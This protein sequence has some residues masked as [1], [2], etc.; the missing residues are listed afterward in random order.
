MKTIK[1]LIILL[2]AF[3][4]IN[5]DAQETEKSKEMKMLGIKTSS[6]CEMCKERIEKELAFVK[7]IKSAELDVESKVLTVKYREDKTN[8][9][10]IRKAV[11]DIGYDADDQKSN[12]EAYDKLPK[13]CQKGGHD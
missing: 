8:P 13:C 4:Y 5:V 10:K 3:G 2:C 7:G 11:T 9:E 6:Q 1:T 12:Q